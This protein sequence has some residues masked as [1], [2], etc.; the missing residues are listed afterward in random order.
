MSDSFEIS[1]RSKSAEQLLNMR[2]NRVAWTEEQ[3]TKIKN[4]IINRGLET[5]EEP[6]PWEDGLLENID[7]LDPKSAFESDLLEIMTID[8]KNKEES[9][10]KLVSQI[11]SLASIFAIF[12][13]IF[14]LEIYGEDTILLFI[15]AFT[16]F[17]VFLF[18][19]YLASLVLGALS[20]LMV[21]F[22]LIVY[23]LQ[24]F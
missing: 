8:N 18:K 5:F 17:G 23:Y 20:L 9:N 16:S 3:Y 2:Q 21:V 6:E 1:L 7:R 15:F 11:I 13:L 10:I 14:M 24:S 22:E 19:K 12:C 4:E